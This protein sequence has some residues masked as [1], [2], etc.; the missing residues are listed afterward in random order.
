M[1]SVDFKVYKQAKFPDLLELKISW[2]EINSKQV[3]CLVY[4]IVT[5]VREKN[6]DRK[7]AKARIS[8]RVVR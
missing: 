8:N 5:N 3:N 1:L 6:K 2:E 4:Q 7:E